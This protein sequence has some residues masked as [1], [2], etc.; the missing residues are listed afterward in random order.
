MMSNGTP[1]KQECFLKWAAHSRD[2]SYLYGGSLLE[3]A[4][5]A[6]ARSSG[7]HGHYSPL[8]RAEREFLDASSRAQRRRARVAGHSR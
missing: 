3:A 5:R 2:P 8:I 7:D 1:L 4:V 6:A